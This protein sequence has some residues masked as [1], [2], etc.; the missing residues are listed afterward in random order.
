M[1][2]IISIKDLSNN[3]KTLK[4]ALKTKNNKILLAKDLNA[5]AIKELGC[6]LRTAQRTVKELYNCQQL[7]APLVYKIT[8]NA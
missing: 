3:A 2:R 4:A 1:N 6:S 5:F 7:T 8:I